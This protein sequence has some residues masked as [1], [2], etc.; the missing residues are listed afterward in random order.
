MS[1]L[2]LSSV[3]RPSAAS[4]RAGAW[5]CSPLLAAGA[6]ALLTEPQTPLALKVASGTV[7][8]NCCSRHSALPVPTPTFTAVACKRPSFLPYISSASTTTSIA[9]KLVAGASS[10]FCTSLAVLASSDSRLSRAVKR[11]PLFTLPL[12]GPNSNLPA[13]WA[14]STSKRHAAPS[15]RPLT[16]KRSHCRPPQSNCL[17]CNL[18]AVGR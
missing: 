6:L 3:R 18:N 12:A 13:S 2:K 14:A 17:A 10:M 8:C 9:G 5:A 7:S 4:L 15:R 11:E 16:V 1:S